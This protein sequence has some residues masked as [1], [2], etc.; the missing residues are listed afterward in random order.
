MN[1]AVVC[2]AGLAVFA[3]GYRFYSSYLARRVF[4]LQPDE[5]VPAVE[6]ED[7]ID[8]V[9]TKRHVLF[10]HHYSSIAGAAPIV[11]PVALVRNSYSLLACVVPKIAPRRPVPW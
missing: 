8:Y 10:G 4:D 9:P 7:G 5:P 3:L 6:L 2:L 1:A 11:G